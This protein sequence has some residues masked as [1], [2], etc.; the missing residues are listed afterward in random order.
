MAWYPDAIRKNIP[1]GS[2]DPV[3]DPIGAILH[4]DAGNASTLYHWFSG[5]SGGIESHFFIKKNGKIEQYRDTR[6]EADA[7]L[8]GNSFHRG[9]RRVGFVSIETQGYGGGEWTKDQLASIKRLLRW[10]SNTHDF[11][12]RDN[13]TWDDPGVAY[14]VKYGA[15]G[16]YT[17]VSKTCPGPDRIRQYKNELVPW[18]NGGGEEDDF[19]AMFD[20]KGELKDFIR[21]AVASTPIGAGDNWETEWQ[22]D[23]HVRNQSAYLRKLMGEAREDRVEGNAP[24]LVLLREIASKVGADVDEKA[25]AQSLLP[26]LLA[27]IA[28]QNQPAEVARLVAESLPTNLSQETADLLLLELHEAIGRARQ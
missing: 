21:E 17:N 3:I 23:T 9:G 6:F 27:G 25:L 18:M 10:L 22:L 19:M 1:P 26:H 13:R 15:P 12:L 5:P 14:H 20:N 16:A 4:V 28:E 11:P 24:T 2:N 7:N 8:N